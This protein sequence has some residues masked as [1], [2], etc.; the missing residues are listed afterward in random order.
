[1]A[2]SFAQGATVSWGRGCGTIGRMP[3]PSRTSSSPRSATWFDDDQVRR[4]IDA[5]MS[6][7]IPVLASHIGVRALYLRPSAALPGALSG[8]MMQAVTAV[9][10]NGGGFAGDLRFDDD[11]LPL[12]SDTLSLIYALHVLESAADGEAQLQEFARV[13]Q[14][15]GLMVAV[16]LSPGSLWRLRWRRAGLQAWGTARLSRAAGAAGLAVEELRAIGPA[17]PLAADDGQGGSLGRLLRGAA[18]PFRTSYVLVARK[19]RAGPTAIGRV[20]NAPLR[21]RV[22]PT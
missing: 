12:G 8:N 7:V 13:L 4:I 5:E 20:G 14:P 10:R 6:E 3:G 17:W 15:E 9:Y 18:Q 2:G 11:A 22:S 1:M 21:A 19:R 16:V